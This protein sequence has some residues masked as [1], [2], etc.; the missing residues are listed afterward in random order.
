MVKIQIAT[1]IRGFLN[2]LF[3]N[4]NSNYKVLH[5]EKKSYEKNSK[6]KI[7]LHNI[8]KS[9]YLDRLGVVQS[10]KVPDVGADLLFSYNKFL[11][12]DSKYVIYLETPIALVNY[13]T[14]RANTDLGKRK[15][16][17]KF[18]DPNLMAIICM[19]QAC[20]DTLFDIF[21]I[22]D[23][24]YVGQ[25][26]PYVPSPENVTLETISSKSTTKNLECLFVSKYFTIKGGG[27]LLKAFELLNEQHNNIK[28]TI[29]TPI[30][31]LDKNHKKLIDNNSNITLLDF[32]LSK[33]E[34]NNLYSKSNILVHPSRYDSS[35][36]VILEAMKYGN[37]I[38]ST[39]LFAIPE[40]VVNDLTGYHTQP[41]YRFYNVDNKP[42]DYVWYNRK[43]TIDDATFYDKNVI[44]FLSGKLK[45]LDDNR[46][47]LKRLSVNAHQR[48]TSKEFSKGYI[49]QKWESVF[50]D[51][52][53]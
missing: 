46:Q 5:K 51:I 22:P 36:L 48:S 44:N 21:D 53:K 13:S 3:N 25:I 40:L 42:N 24:L 11:K 15:L 29:V 50:E 30:N 45:E 17:M 47:L 6:L 28:L 7:V 38:L 49:I 31:D 34:L 27:D 19:S 39:D 2:E 33:E 43:S 14:N 16:K 41:H 23:N 10:I 12:T 18:Q 9:K 52:L 4:L 35:P 37:V 26:Y 32:K 1:D 20:Y 8:A